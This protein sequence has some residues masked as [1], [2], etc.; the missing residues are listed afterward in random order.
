MQQSIAAGKAYDHGGD[1]LHT[2]NCGA[3]RAT[4]EPARAANGKI[5]AT[6][7]LL[8]V[9]WVNHIDPPQTSLCSQVHCQ[10]LG[11]AMSNVRAYA[12]P[13]EVHRNERTACAKRLLS[14]VKHAGNRR[15]AVV[16]AVTAAI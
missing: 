6:S 15:P 1:A 12:R 9:Y 8:K 5:V 11:H 7:Q 10:V 3:W 14:G 2:A 13:S 16:A 4:A